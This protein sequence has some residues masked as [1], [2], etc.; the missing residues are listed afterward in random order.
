M[1]QR[2]TLLLRVG[3]AR[4][5]LGRHAAQ[6]FFSAKAFDGPFGHPE[7]ETPGGWALVTK[8]TIERCDELRA[9]CRRA[10]SPP[11][12]PLL[13]QLDNLSDTICLAVDAAELCRNVHADDEMRAKAQTAFE[14]LSN[15]ISQLNTDME[16]YQSLAR[17]DDDP[18]VA[19][20]LTPE[21]R[22]MSHLLREEFERDGIHLDQAGRGHIVNLQDAVIQLGS[23]FQENINTAG[24]TITLTA[25]EAGAVPESILTRSGPNGT[26]AIIRLAGINP[27]RQK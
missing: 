4:K 14:Q 7:L 12:L 26:K 25:D 18:A 1:L 19:S 22:R 17:S 24:G 6:A 20:Q 2:C 23:L 16:L 21:Q 15:Y 11:G 27:P 10:D 13:Q 3:S 9:W 8:Q 5:G